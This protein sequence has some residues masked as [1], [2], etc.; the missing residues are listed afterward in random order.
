MDFQK[1]K[2]FRGKAVQE[3]KCSN[4]SVVRIESSDDGIQN[5]TTH[6]CLEQV[7]Y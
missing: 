7:W 4:L 1:S 2:Y 6:Y 5:P 3:S